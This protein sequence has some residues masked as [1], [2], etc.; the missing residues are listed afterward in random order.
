MTK[1]QKT[2]LISA[3]F[4]IF[5]VFLIGY[6]IGRPM[7][8]FVSDPEAF[9]DWIEAKGIWGVLCFIIMNIFQVFLAV[10]PGGPFEVGAGYAFGVVKGT[11]ICLFA[12]CTASILVF[13]FTRKFG[14]RFVE[15]FVSKEKIES[16]R[17]LKS[18][19]KS[20]LILF[21]IFLIPGTPK[22]ALSYLV[23]LTDIKLSHWVLI[24]LFGRLPAIFLSVSG[25]NALGNSNYKTAIL[26]L[27]LLVLSC[28]IGF[29]CYR[30]FN[31]D[32]K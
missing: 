18:S 12:M 9:R 21:L 32:P 2:K 19:R 26:L 31:H 1:Q 4:A 14:L 15:L 6:F 13:L 20:E 29:F 22:D 17:I 11:C 25:G 28:T 24:S 8:Q 23:G 16:A 10:L 27:A 30:K 5:L 3:L 7:V